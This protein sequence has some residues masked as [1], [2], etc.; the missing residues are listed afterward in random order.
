MEIDFYKLFETSSILM[1]FTVIA[2]GLLVG[3]IKFGPVELGSTTGVLLV[4]LLFGHLGFVANPQMG[5]FGFSIFIFAVG[6]QA[7]PTFFSVFL[8]DGKNYI[9]LAVVVAVTAITL[10]LTIGRVIGLEY[11]MNAGL[12]AGA[13][14]STP[15]LAGAQDAISGGHASLPEGMTAETAAQNVGVAYAITYIFGTI[16]LILFIRYLPALLHIDLPEEAK[17]LARERGFG[18]KKKLAVTASDIPLIRAYALPKTAVG[19][20]IMEL[21][22]Q[23]KKRGLPLRIR[24]KNKIIE[25]THD[26]KLE[27]DD[28]ISVIGSIEEHDSSSELLGSEVLDPELLNY[29]VV[30]KEIIAITTEVVGQSLGDLDIPGNYGC[31][32]RNLSR[33]SIDLPINA[34][35]VLNKGDRLHVT[36]E[37][38]RLNDLATEVGRIEAEETQTDLFTFSLGI[39]VGVMIGLV[40]LKLGVVSIG[41]GSAGGLLLVGIL[42]G[43]L[44]SMYPTFGGVPP[45]ARN[46]LMELGLVLFM[47]GVGLGAGAG[48]V[49]G[50][51]SAG[52]QLILGGVIVTLV[53]V[54]VA[55]FI[56][57]KFLNMNPAILLGSI[58]GSMTSTPSLNVVTEAAKSEIPA[59]GYAGTYTFA[60]VL[61]TFAGT[62]L[63]RL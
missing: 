18:A 7:G 19:K 2:T 27:K 3:R 1:I 61:L 55:Y 51:K 33:A 50:F 8:T 12:M 4:A 44:R 57:R 62:I 15:T 42:I 48:I 43:F 5:T 17:K 56:G 52:L 63:M 14:T 38:S 46:V 16:G 36:G 25:A 40:M 31:F 28:T 26:L 37:E 9:I 6:L 30:T 47:A 54:L 13:L 49:E 10:A 34:G 22:A 29:N 24:R 45:A 11:G 35:T 32:V 60:N 53:P 20:T 23:N 59:L 39:G 58:T 21:R 41:L